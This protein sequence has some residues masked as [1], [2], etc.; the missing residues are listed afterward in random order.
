MIT[1][2]MSNFRD[3]RRKVFLIKNRKKDTS[4][5]KNLTGNN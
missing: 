3:I 4:K 5:P 2:G 1:K